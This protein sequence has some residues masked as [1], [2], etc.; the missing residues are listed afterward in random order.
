M[1][2]RQFVITQVSKSIQSLKEYEPSNGFPVQLRNIGTDLW[3]SM[4]VSH[5]FCCMSHSLDC[6]ESC[7]SALHPSIPQREQ[8]VVSL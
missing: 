6:D 1:H 3:V 8:L 5:G 7:M 4:N 2:L